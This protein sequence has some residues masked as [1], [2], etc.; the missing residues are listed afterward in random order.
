MPRFQFRDIVLVI[1]GAAAVITVWL[2][3]DLSKDNHK[4]VSKSDLPA[5]TDRFRGSQEPDATSGHDASEY[6]FIHIAEAPTFDRCGDVRENCVV[7][8]DTFW[9][10]GEKIRIADIDAPEIH[11]PKC[12]YER[13]LGTRA[14]SR[15]IVLLNSG[16]FDL[17]SDM[18]NPRDRYGRKLAV[19]FRRGHSL[20]DNLVREG[21]AR[22][23]RGQR[24]RWC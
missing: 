3:H 24:Q 9:L 17:R 16:D 2:L 10:H 5:S 21:L 22:T 4:Q 7:D 12:S 18:T 19:V 6:D 15:L 14:A 11:E 20:G 1:A 23:W 8:G 13:D